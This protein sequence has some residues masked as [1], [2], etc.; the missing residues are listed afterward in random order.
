MPSPATHLRAPL[1]WLLLPLM[2]GLTAAKLWPP[3]SVGLWPL[4]TAAGALTIIAGWCALKPGRAAAFLWAACLSLSG[5]LAGFVLLHV[6]APD[7]HRA[8]DRAPREIT[9]T[10]E[11]LQLFPAAPSARNLTGIGRITGATETEREVS[12]RRVYF[13]AIRKI[14]VS[15][16]RSG[17]YL[18]RGVIGPLPRE[19]AAAGFN[20]YLANLG[21]REKIARAQI[22]R[23]EKPPNGFR[24]FCSR[25]E[26]RLEQILQRGLERHP[27]IS[28]LY[29]G[30]LLG[31]K[32]VLS[33]DQQ[34]AFMRSGT[35]HIFSISGLHVGVIAV[36]LQSLLR[37]VRVPRRPAVI[38]TLSLLWLYVQI[39]GASSPAE[40]SWLMIAFL[41]GSQ[42]FRLPGNG[43]A[44]LAAAALVTLLLDPLQLFST[45]FQMSY[46]V[47]TALVVM[48]VPLAEKWLARWRPFHLLPV[49]NWRWYH[50]CSSWLSRTL[51]GSVA[52]CWVAFLASAP[53]GI[54][55]FQV[56]SPGS[57]L[58]NLII[59]PVS[60]LALIAGFLS[61]LTGLCG[62]LS[63]SVLFNAAAA[64]T[65]LVMD[66]LVLHGINLPGVYYPAQFT[67]AWL[68]PVS[69][70]FMLAVMLA[71]L[72]GGWSRRYG[73]YW[74]PAIVLLLLI[75]FGVK[76]S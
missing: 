12:G 74:P 9:V 45:G 14:S 57:L 15:P 23:E 66:W 55:Y 36:A 76:F 72:A 29:L 39:T 48:G 63:L 26:T 51:V 44:A 33:T 56:L 65:L 40:R 8:D 64:V 60:S 2:A 43:L 54:G 22:I 59:I 10:L 30:M 34:N 68:A 18:L 6:A 24:R 32:A 50:H 49:G 46:T 31:E 67:R 62:L 1:L 3:P 58:A 20:D 71:G 73:G 70:V 28:S 11:A 27:A 25:A 5:A 13:S 47:V 21:I 53:S 38:I 4:A 75:I 35:F 41:L 69:L 7:L 61:L 16:Q 52:A 42:V 17:R 37:L 19:A